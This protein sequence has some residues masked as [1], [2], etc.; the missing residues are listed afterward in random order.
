MLSHQSAISAELI[1]KCQKRDEFACLRG[2]V[3]DGAAAYGHLNCIVRRSTSARSISRQTFRLG[4]P[5]RAETKGVRAGTSTSR[6]RSCSSSSNTLPDFSVGIISAASAPARLVR[7][8]GEP[9][10]ALGQSRHLWAVAECL[11]WA[12]RRHRL[13]LLMSQRLSAL[14]PAGVL[15][16]SPAKRRGRQLRC[17]RDGGPYRCGAYR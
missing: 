11:L 4:S 8:P 13:K 3:D 10:S 1:A 6:R 17:I 2:R 14:M 16:P 12:N 5:S 15:R 7:V 9:M